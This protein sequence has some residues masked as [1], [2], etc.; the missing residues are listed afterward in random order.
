MKAQEAHVHRYAKRVKRKVPLHKFD[1]I[2]GQLVSSLVGYDYLLMWKC[3]CGDA[4]AY[5]LERQLA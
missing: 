3:E 4:E 1:Y 5:D 2:E